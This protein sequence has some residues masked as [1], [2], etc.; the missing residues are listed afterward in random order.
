[1]ELT[2]YNINSLD[3]VDVCKNLRK[4]RGF[5][6]G[7]TIRVTRDE[8]KVYRFTFLVMSVLSY[9]SEME[10]HRYATSTKI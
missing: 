8:N 6:T 2:F 3:A 4:I 5:V 7:Q 1:M 10:L 9:D